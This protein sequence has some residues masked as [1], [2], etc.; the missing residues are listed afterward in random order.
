MRYLGGKSRIARQIAAVINAE[1]GTRLLWDPFCGGLAS[2]AA[3]G[4]EL[5]CSDVHADLIALYRAVQA[6]PTCL[7]WIPELTQ[8][9]YAWA[10]ANADALDPA[11]RAF[12]GFGCSFRGQWFRGRAEPR[13]NQQGTIYSVMEGSRRW[14]KKH[15]PA[16]RATFSVADFLQPC[17]RTW[18]AR[19]SPYIYLDP[20]YHGTQGYTGVPAFDHEAF[21]YRVCEWAD[22]GAVCWVSEYD[23]PFGEI[24]WEAPRKKS[25]VSRSGE[26]PME[27]LYRV[28]P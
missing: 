22:A 17:D 21:E 2:A 9:D 13:P 7:D 16:M 25:G 27:R 12:V 11:T 24:V 4:G 23:F 1:R 18:V 28:G 6:D 20:P 3:L 19:V 8:E 26:Q 10:K 5:L 14:L 15:V